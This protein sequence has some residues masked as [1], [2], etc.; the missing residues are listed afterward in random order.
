MYFCPNLQS[1]ALFQELFLLLLPKN[2]AFHYFAVTRVAKLALPNLSMPVLHLLNLI[3]L[4]GV[5]N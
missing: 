2:I 3:I 4:E 5:A 1:N